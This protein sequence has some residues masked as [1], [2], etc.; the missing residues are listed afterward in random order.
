MEQEPYELTERHLEDRC[1]FTKM[2]IDWK[3]RNVKYND[4]YIYNDDKVKMTIVMNIITKISGIPSSQIDL[5]N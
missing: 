2:K 4:A 1:T 3:S 5:G